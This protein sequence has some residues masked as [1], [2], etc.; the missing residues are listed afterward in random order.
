[1]ELRIFITVEKTTTE[2]KSYNHPFLRVY[3]CV[4]NKNVVTT[5]STVGRGIS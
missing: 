1:M 4:F 2:I 5:Y 3:T